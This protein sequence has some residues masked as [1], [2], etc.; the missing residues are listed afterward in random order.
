[1]RYTQV[2]SA[3]PC[4][5]GGVLVSKEA[6]VE[7]ARLSPVQGEAIYTLCRIGRNEVFQKQIWNTNI[8]TRHSN[9]GPLAY[10]VHLQ[11]RA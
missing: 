11:S 8:N 2:T 5:N 6:Q 7:V 9:I 4:L 10:E 1:M 3:Y